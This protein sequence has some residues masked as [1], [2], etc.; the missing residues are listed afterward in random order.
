MQIGAQLWLFNAVLDENEMENILIPLKDSGYDF[1]EKLYNKPP[2]DAQVLNRLKMSCYA[3]HIALSIM[4][5]A[6]ESAS[7]EKN[8]EVTDFVR[9]LGARIVCVSGLLQWRERSADDYR[10]SAAALNQWGRRLQAEGIA[11]HYHN[12]EFEFEAVEGATTGM[13]ILLS[14]LEPSVISLC[15]DAGWAALAGEDSVH[16]M[17][18][19]GDRIGTLHLRD[20]RGSVS[21]P[22]GSGDIDLSGILSLLPSL[23]NLQGVLVEQDPG[24]ETPVADMIQ[25][26]LFLKNRFGL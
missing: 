15:F 10:R 16:F 9:N 18:R 12:H 8:E 19:H 21:V 20:F 22:L 11:L 24:T 14:L 2:H 25:S 5:P 6:P 3:T 23:P 26:R 17:R 7:D 1:V 4:P 13:D